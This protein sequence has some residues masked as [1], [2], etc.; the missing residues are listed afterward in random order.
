MILNRQQANAI[1]TGRKTTHHILHGSLQEGARVTI[2]VRTRPR[3]TEIACYVKLLSVETR[4]LRDLTMREAKAEG[5]SGPRG[6][7]NWRKAW[8]QQHD[9]PWADRQKHSDAGLNE[10]VVRDRFEAQY[11]GN[12]VT[13]LEFELAEPP[14]RFLAPTRTGHPYTSDPRRAIDELAVAPEEFVNQLANKAN[15]TRTATLA[16][17]RKDAALE[18]FAQA[19]HRARGKTAN[20][21]VRAAERMAQAVD[22][23]IA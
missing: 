6:P 16:Q 23:D 15:E 21:M 1:A 4:P 13:V 12:P 5:Y 3:E 9:Q 11:V 17:A 18:S 14:D 20:N 2:Q 22:R 7:I 10:T 8:L 19:L